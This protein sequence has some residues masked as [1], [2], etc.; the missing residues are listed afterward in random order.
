MIDSE[1]STDDYEFFQ[2]SVGA[3]TK[4]SRNVNIPS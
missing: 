3:V 1:C 2:V 4:K